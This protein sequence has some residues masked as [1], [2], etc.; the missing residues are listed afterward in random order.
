MTVS[1]QDDLQL[2]EVCHTGAHACRLTPGQN[3][4]YL[5]LM[6]CSLNELIVCH[7]RCT[8]IYRDLFAEYWQPLGWI[9]TRTTMRTGKNVMSPKVSLI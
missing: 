3:A 4:R 7:L 8:I 9:Q 6:V 5:Q 1:A 2:T